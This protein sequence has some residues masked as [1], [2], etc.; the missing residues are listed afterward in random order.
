MSRI[1]EHNFLSGLSRFSLYWLRNDAVKLIINLFYF[2]MTAFVYASDQR[3]TDKCIMDI[4]LQLIIA[5]IYF[6]RSTCVKDKS[7]C[8]NTGYVKVMCWNYCDFRCRVQFFVSVISS[9]SGIH[10]SFS[11][12]RIKA[13]RYCNCKQYKL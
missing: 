6:N 9:K 1:R 5:I 13:T 12:K 3:L 10:K 11:K 2:T 4:I 8:V 7:D